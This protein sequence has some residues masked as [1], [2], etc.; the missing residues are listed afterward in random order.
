MIMLL[1]RGES[2][3][4]LASFI[5]FGFPSV[6]PNMPPREFPPFAWQLPPELSGCGA[7]LTVLGRAKA[8]RLD[9]FE[10]HPPESIFALQFSE[11]L[12]IHNYTYVAILMKGPPDKS[13]GKCFVFTP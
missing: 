5:G 7:R 1:A 6:M 9:L 13:T 2:L 8:Q 10:Q 11:V 12:V 3:S 4:H